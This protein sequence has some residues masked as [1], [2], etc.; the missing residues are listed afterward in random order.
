MSSAIFCKMSC[1]TRE[2][3][4]VC[5][6]ICHQ[7][8]LNCLPAKGEL[9]VRWCHNIFGCVKLNLQLQVDAHQRRGALRRHMSAQQMVCLPLLLH[10]HHITHRE[11]RE[12]MLKRS[13]KA[14][15]EEKNEKQKR[16]PLS[17]PLD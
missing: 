2:E 1:L 4:E 16:E 5:V 8:P 10:H 3:C 9:C 15:L 12:R 13:L 14:H 17:K 11:G 6:P 7:R